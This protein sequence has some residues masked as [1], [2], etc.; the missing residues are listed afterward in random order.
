MCV[1][2]WSNCLRHCPSRVDLISV[3]IRVTARKK[4][5]YK[6]VF[7]VAKRLLIKTYSMMYTHIPANKQVCFILNK[8]LQLNTVVPQSIF[9]LHAVAV[10]ERPFLISFIFVKCVHAVCRTCCFCT[11]PGSVKLH[12]NSALQRRAAE[13]KL[14]HEVNLQTKKQN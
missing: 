5:K 3:Q 4:H 8:T 1:E 12:Q 2:L 13:L 9:S 11:L 10:E 7:K 14:Q 6:H